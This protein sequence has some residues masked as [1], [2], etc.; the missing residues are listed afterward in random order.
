M[1]ERGDCICLHEPFMYYYYVHLARK[2]MPYFQIDPDQPTGFTDII[3]MFFERAQSQPVF[4]KDMAYYVLPEIRAH[5]NLATALNHVFLLRDPYRS[6]VSYFNLDNDVASD[7]IGIN[8]QKQ[9]FD[10][11]ERKSGKP[12]LVLLSDHIQSNPQ[13]AA[14]LL[15]AYL[16]LPANYNALQWQNTHTP[17]EWGQVETWHQKTM[18]TSGIQKESGDAE[19]ARQ[20]F[21]SLAKSHP[22]LQSLFD[23]HQASYIFLKGIGDQQW[24]NHLEQSSGTTV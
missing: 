13:M 19:T 18:Q 12:P 16:D 9:L 2:E 1:R 8:A 17:K 4:V 20:N 10:W 15:W 23:D 11:I 6:I 5:D 24:L 3:D 7:E 22:R 14:E 21:H